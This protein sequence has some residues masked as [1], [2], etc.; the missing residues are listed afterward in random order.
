MSAD[1]ISLLGFLVIVKCSVRAQIVQPSNSQFSSP[2]IERKPTWNSNLYFLTPKLV[3]TK[4]SA[5]FVIIHKN[6]N[7]CFLIIFI[8]PLFSEHDY[9]SYWVCHYIV[10]QYS[11]STKKH[12]LK[13]LTFVSHENYF[14][15][16]TP[17]FH[18]LAPK[19]HINTWWWD[20]CIQ[21]YLFI[22]WPWGDRIIGT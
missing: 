20:E 22:R 18:G 1:V 16:T 7:S 14:S 3:L 8:Q 4:S 5:Y 11:Y 17:Y 9:I 19:K 2:L 12:L 13:K 21:T 15:L 6:N 10:W